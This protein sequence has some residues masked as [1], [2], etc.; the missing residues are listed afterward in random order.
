MI[1]NII[2][3]LI[4]GKNKW[5]TKKSIKTLI[6]VHIKNIIYDKTKIKII[7]WKKSFH[8]KIKKIIHSTLR[9]KETIFIRFAG[10]KLKYNIYISNF[11]IMK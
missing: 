9:A 8:L 4:M 11:N 3:A 6:K 7:S 1:I 2:I 10:S 5:K